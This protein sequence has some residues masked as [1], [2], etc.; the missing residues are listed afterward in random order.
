MSGGSYNYLYGAMDLQDLLN[1]F[2]ELEDMANRLDGLS[3]AE[4]PGSTA[5]ARATRDL[6]QKLNIWE[7]HA[8]V[9]VANL[10]D[11]WHSVEWWDSCD[12]GPEEVK[13]AL[14]KLTGSTS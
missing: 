12:S 6:I 5:A 9:S 1:K 14:D 10:S 11:V 8:Q 13:K 2:R 4:F 7:S 3:E